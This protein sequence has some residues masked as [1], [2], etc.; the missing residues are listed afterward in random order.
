M[1]EL[2]KRTIQP[3]NSGQ[4]ACTRGCFMFLMAH[5][6]KIIHHNE[7][8][9]P[10][11]NNIKKFRFRCALVVV[12]HRNCG[13]VTALW[14][15]VTRAIIC[16]KSPTEGLKNTG[17]R[18]QQRLLFAPLSVTLCRSAFHK[19]F[20]LHS[21]VFLHQ[22]YFVLD[23]K[24]AESP[25]HMMDNSCVSSFRLPSA[26]VTPGIW[27]TA[28]TKLP[29]S[30]SCS[31]AWHTVISVIDICPGWRRRVT[32]GRDVTSQSSCIIGAMPLRRWL[33]SSPAWTPSTSARMAQLLT[34]DHTMTGFRA[35][36]GVGQPQRARA[37]ASQASQSRP[38]GFRYTEK[39]LE[40]SAA[41]PVLTFN[42]A[43]RA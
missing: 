10:L 32:R 24:R 15:H 34:S 1:W 12:L 21:A 42:A 43:W 20:L 11:L 13:T 38:E 4:P 5:L 37:A 33:S 28:N 19:G 7:E 25:R 36:A 29:Y 14:N 17:W 27:V 41:R 35:V 6:S 40:A 22:A 18:R 31:C 3:E 30:P 9:Q 39:L 8:K 2:F 23:R 16:H 26:V